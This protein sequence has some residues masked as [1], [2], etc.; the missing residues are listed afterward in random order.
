LDWLARLQRRGCF[1][2]RRLGLNTTLTLWL[3]ERTW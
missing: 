1:D 3:G 2:S